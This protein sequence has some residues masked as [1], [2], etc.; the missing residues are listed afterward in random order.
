MKHINLYILSRFALCY[1]VAI[2]AALLVFFPLR[3]YGQG[4]DFIV[5]DSVATFSFEPRQSF[6]IYYFDSGPVRR[7]EALLV[8][9][10]SPDTADN[11]EEKLFFAGTSVVRPPGA[12]E[13]T[14]V[15]VVSGKYQRY[16]MTPV[17][18]LGIDSNRLFS[19]SVSKL[20]KYIKKQQTVLESWKAQY[21]VQQNNLERLRRDAEIIGNLGRIVEVQQDIER[22]QGRLVELEEDINQLKEFIKLA[23]SS[24]PPRNFKRREVQL[25]RDLSELADAAKRA[26]ENEELRREDAVSM[27][28]HKVA[29]IEETRF[30]DLEALKRELAGL[31]QRRARIAGAASGVGT[32]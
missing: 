29:L 3:S 18:K 21:A 9:G 25:A 11:G 24:P 31:R 20:Q 12:R 19:G 6:F 8:K 7:R 23:G 10:V 30:E 17:Q 15:L 26:E 1:F 28:Q 14:Y 32:E 27:L 2:S 5:L 16:Y 22:E 4:A 13:V